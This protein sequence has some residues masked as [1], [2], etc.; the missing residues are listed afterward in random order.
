MSDTTTFT[1]PAAVPGADSVAVVKQYGVQYIGR[2]PTDGPAVWEMICSWLGVDSND[3]STGTMQ[4]LIKAAVYAAVQNLPKN[5][6]GI[7]GRPFLDGNFLAVDTE[8]QEPAEMDVQIPMVLKALVVEA[9][10]QYMEN[11]PQGPLANAV[12]L[13]GNLVNVD[14]A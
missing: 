8:G 12:S 10:E 14:P 3:V 6:P 5:P 4:G 7:K 11:L 9:L 2:V 1:F 13:N